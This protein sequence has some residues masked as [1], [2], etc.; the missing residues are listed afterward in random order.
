MKQR[1]SLWTFGH[2]LVMLIATIIAVIY[3]ALFVLIWSVSLSLTML[4]ATGHKTWVH[5]HPV[6]GF[7]NLVTFG[8][9]VLLIFTLAMHHVFSPL[10]F[11][12]MI[13]TVIIA[14]GVDGY[15]ARKYHQAT[16][17]GEVFDMEV[18]AFLALALTFLI[19]MN[20]PGTGWVLGA[21]L[22][23]YGF[24]ILYRLLGWHHRQR[25]AMPESRVIAVVFFISL[26]IPMLIEWNIAVWIVG[27]GCGLVAFSFFRE[28]FLIARVK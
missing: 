26:L 12:V 3:D 20:H 18:D 7:A 16:Q 22:L 15:L 11:I 13:V 25:P 17:F 4:I 1:I 9:F 27:M 5:L 2:A 24:A 28:F 23:R 21:G 14:D 8:R 10:M 6:G 19:W